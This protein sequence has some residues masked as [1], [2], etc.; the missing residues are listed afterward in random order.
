MYSLK[1]MV[2]IFTYIA[3]LYFIMRYLYRLSA[4]DYTYYIYKNSLSSG[5]SVYVALQ[6]KIISK[7]FNYLTFLI[8]IYFYILM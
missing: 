7:K 2:V 8:F 1:D 5:N 3:I 4:K 6:K